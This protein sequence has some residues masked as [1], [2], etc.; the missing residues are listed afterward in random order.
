MNKCCVWLWL[1]TVF[2]TRPRSCRQ[3]LVHFLLQRKYTAGCVSLAWVATGR[4]RCPTGSCSL[5]HAKHCAL[6]CLDDL[7]AESTVLFSTWQV[8]NLSVL[9]CFCCCFTFY[10]IEARAGHW[11]PTRLHPHHWKSRLL[12]SKHDDLPVKFSP[13]QH[14]LFRFSRC[15]YRTVLAPEKLFMRVCVCVYR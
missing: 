10:S 5:L 6:Q 12:L 3:K 11:R 15:F 8:L 7:S 2:T 1:C 4:L 14:V 13:R 9:L